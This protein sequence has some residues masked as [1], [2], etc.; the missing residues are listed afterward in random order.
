MNDKVSEQIS[1]L[2]DGELPD[3]EQELLLR[4]LAAEPALRK[5]WERIHLM[6]DA[7]HNELP[8]QLGPSLSDRVMAA[9]E[10]EP[11]PVAEPGWKRV[12]RQL[13]RPLAGLAVAASVAALAILGLEQVMGPGQEQTGP[14][15]QLAALDAAAEPRV[16]GT[17]WDQPEAGNQLNAYLVNHNEHTGSSLQGMMNYVR[18]AGYDAQ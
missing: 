13:G 11:L 12:G 9:L 16:V 5:E 10:H 7:L 2:A 14:T 8:S 15:P 3:S 4:R 17:R 6:R 1:A 18:I